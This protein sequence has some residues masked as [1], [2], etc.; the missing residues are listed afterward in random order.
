MATLE[1]TTRVGCRVG[2][3]YCPQKPLAK[4][5]AKRSNHLMMGLDAFKT[6]IDKLPDDS[7]VVFSGYSE[8]FVNPECTDMILYAKKEKKFKVTVF[9][10][11]EG[12]TQSDLDRIKDIEFEYFIVHLPDN[13]GRMNI[14][15]DEEFFRIMDFLIEHIPNISFLLTR[16]KGWNEDLHPKVKAYFKR[17]KKFVFQHHVHLRAGNVEVEG[18]NLRRVKGKMRE[19][20]RL[21]VNVL[22]PNGDVTLCC[23]DFGQKHVIGNLFQDSFE[24][25]SK[26]DEYLKVMAGHEDESI[27]SL[28][29]TCHPYGQPAN[30]FQ[31]NY[32]IARYV[33]PGMT[34]LYAMTAAKR[35]LFK[36]SRNG[37]E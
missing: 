24:D 5:Y 26:S 29:R 19:C 17:K 3:S 11:T 23:M 34:Q 6:C 2:C 4:N 18:I 37:A 1:V 21:K 9:T 20:P 30:W 27:D 22:L 12:I 35:L 31:R 14:D 32:E 8:P 10:T 25:L 33:L 28:C 15:P 16:G 13:E 36:F 7:T